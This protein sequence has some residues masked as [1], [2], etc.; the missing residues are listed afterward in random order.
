M[1]RALINAPSTAERGQIIEI[2]ALI[3]HP[4]ETG[5]RTGPDGNLVPR[6]IIK[7]FTCD[8]NGEEIFSADLFP[9]IAA[10]PF[11]SFTTVATETGLI[12]FQWI[13]DQDQVQVETAEITVE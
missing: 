8:Y 11:L 2:K 12:T 10:N 13:D 7:R 6:N 4:M 9:A 3:S 1:A 5:F